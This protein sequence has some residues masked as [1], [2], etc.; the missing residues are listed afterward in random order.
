MPT[1]AVQAS[2]RSSLKTLRR[3][4]L[5]ALLIVLLGSEYAR[6][7]S[8]T[9]SSVKRSSS[10]IAI[11][12]NGATLLVVNPDSNSVT[13][14]DTASR[15]AIAELPVGTDPRTVAVDDTGS[16]A[17]VANRGSGNLSVIDLAARQ[18]ITTVAAGDRPY[19]IL[20]NPGAHRLYVAEQGA[21]RV[22]VLDAATFQ[23]IARIAVADRPSGL[24][25]SND[26]RTLLVTHLL[27]HTITVVTVQPYQVFLPLFL[28]STL[29]GQSA[30]I[31]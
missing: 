7:A 30:P 15:S 13:L 20:I 26:G 4:M 27:T 14:V 6:G 18:V 22:L 2:H 5:A 24:A 31:C 29:F 25:L 17:Y 12:A 8:L 21:D 19:G 9:P 16:R 23:P 1:C 11:T 28:R 3:F 10:A